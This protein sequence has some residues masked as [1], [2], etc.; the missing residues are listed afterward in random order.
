M[1]N[2]IQAWRVAEETTA[3]GLKRLRDGLPEAALDDP[4]RDDDRRALGA[5]FKARWNFDVP[6]QWMGVDTLV[7]RFH[8]E[9]TKH[10]T[11]LY[12]IHK[13]STLASANIL[14]PGFKRQQLSEGV[15]LRVGTQADDS[16]AV[17]NSTTCMQ[18]LFGLKVVLLTMALAGSYKV[19]AQGPSG[20]RSS[21]STSHTRRRT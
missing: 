18:Y 3:R 12:R 6:D 4:L 8:R 17:H 19:M 7:A 5:A 1:A 14:G 13:V 16:P 9:F 10:K 15:E 21:G 20:A 2:V 11:T